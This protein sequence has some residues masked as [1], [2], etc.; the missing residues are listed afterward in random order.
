MCKIGEHFCRDDD[1]YIRDTLKPPCR[2]KDPAMEGEDKSDDAEEELGSNKV[3]NPFETVYKM[4]FDRQEGR[5]IFL[6][7]HG[8][9]E[10]NLTARIGGNPPLTSKGQRYA[11][12]LGSYINSLEIP[13]LKVITSSLRRTHMT[14]A[15]I[16]ADK[17]STSMLDELNSGFL[18]GYTYGDVK[19]LYPEEYALRKKDKLRYRYPGGESYLDC[20]ERILNTLVCIESHQDETYLIVAHQG[21][22]RCVIG[23]LLRVELDQI[24][25]ISV[26]QHAIIRVVWSNGRYHIE[27]IRL[28]VDETS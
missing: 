7:R 28:P 13:N 21:L 1:R 8:E 10:Y 11:K 3:M 5:T 16:N 18:D 15:F 20:C 25:Y 24:P 19:V 22:L 12:A 23:Y 2:H 17:A 27:Y 4:N 26:P 9:S 6:S 14:A